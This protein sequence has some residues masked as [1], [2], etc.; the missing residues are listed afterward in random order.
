MLKRFEQF[1]LEQE[2]NQDNQENQDNQTSQE[3]EKPRTKDIGIGETADGQKVMATMKLENTLK[4][5]PEEFTKI[6]NM[7]VTQYERDMLVHT[8]GFLIFLGIRG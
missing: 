4:F 7:R 1:I 5:S 6:G 3:T 2:D 8:R